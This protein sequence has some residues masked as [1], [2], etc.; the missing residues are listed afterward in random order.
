MTEDWSF[1]HIGPDGQTY[2][3]NDNWEYFRRELESREDH[4]WHHRRAFMTLHT[5][6]KRLATLPGYNEDIMC[7]NT[8][9]EDFCLIYEA[10]PAWFRTEKDPT[11]AQDSWSIFI[12]NGHKKTPGEPV[13][14]FSTGY[15]T[16]LVRPLYGITPTIY[17]LFRNKYWLTDNIHDYGIGS[18]SP[19]KIEEK[20]R[21]GSYL[22]REITEPFNQDW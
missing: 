21:N 4:N 12:E 9:L 6:R 20:R 14:L 16:D 17:A 11:A 7:I 2:L 10:Y 18:F 13:I 15:G 8:V 19:T 5:P 1:K 3:H 22:A